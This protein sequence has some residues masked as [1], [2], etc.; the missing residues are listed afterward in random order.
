MPRENLYAVTTA[1]QRVDPRMIR[2]VTKWR[3]PTTTNATVLLPAKRDAPRRATNTMTRWNTPSG[4]ALEPDALQ[5]LPRSMVSPKQDRSLT[6]AAS[7]PKLTTST[8]MTFQRGARKGMPGSSTRTM[9]SVAKRSVSSST[10]DGA[11]VFTRV[12]IEKVVRRRAACWPAGR[13]RD[14]RLRR[15]GSRR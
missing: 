3:P 7:S 5:P 4:R 10:S 15:T 6:L 1:M 8:Q 9:I 11:R 14:H 13:G 12:T 2:A